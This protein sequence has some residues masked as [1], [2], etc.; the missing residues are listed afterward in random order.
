[1]PCTTSACRSV[2]CTGCSIRLDLDDT[3]ESSCRLRVVPAGIV[4]SR[5]GYRATRSM[6]PLDSSGA[7][8]TTP[9]AGINVRHAAIIGPAAS[10][11]FLC[12]SMAFPPQGAQRLAVEAYDCKDLARA[13]FV[14]ALAS[15]TSCVPADR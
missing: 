15:A 11:L 2:A 5:V 9:D 12:V 8:D 3:V 7:A 10:S 14:P 6:V 4:T 1:M 13:L